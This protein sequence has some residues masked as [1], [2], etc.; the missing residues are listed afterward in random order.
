MNNHPTH[1]AALAALL[2]S[3]C[4]A[5]PSA[6]HDDRRPAAAIADPF[7]AARAAVVASLKDPDSARFGSFSHGKGSAVCGLVNARNAAGGYTGAR[8][9][10]YSPDGPAPDRLYIDEDAGDWRDR[11]IM[12]EIF[13]ERGCSIGADQAKALEARKALEE[14]DRSEK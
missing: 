10:V 2:L 12:A 7:A 9:F 13:A 4:D 8:A 6:A 11:G 14:M 3:G 1:W 5:V